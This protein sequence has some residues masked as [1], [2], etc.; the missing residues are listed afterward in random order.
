MSGQD[1]RS[2]R[3]RFDA[4]LAHLREWRVTPEVRLG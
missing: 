3:E 4:A 1:V 2:Q